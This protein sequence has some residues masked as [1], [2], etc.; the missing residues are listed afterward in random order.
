MLR[1]KLGDINATNALGCAVASVTFCAPRANSGLVSSKYPLGPLP[2]L[3]SA[4]TDARKRELAL[5][6]ATR[7]NKEQQLRAITELVA[8]ARSELS[9]AD[10]EARERLEAGLAR[11]VDL[12]WAEDE[13][14]ARLAALSELES[15]AARVTEELG[16]AEVARSEASRALSLAEA[17]QRAVERHREA[18]ERQREQARAERAD[19][20]AIERWT[21]EHAPRSG[22]R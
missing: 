16:R 6:E 2:A 19:E 4:A 20:E 8:A 12:A 15:R 14:R 5:A 13:R 11:A 21:S 9:R 18:W 22:P 17:E 10:M 1:G 7:A 3:R